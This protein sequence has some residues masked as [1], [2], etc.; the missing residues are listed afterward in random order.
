[1]QISPRNSFQS[2]ERDYNTAASRVA[3]ERAKSA[4]FAVRLCQIDKSS[5]N[6]MFTESRRNGVAHKFFGDSG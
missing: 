5:L 6:F 3:R 2:S 4:F 1:M